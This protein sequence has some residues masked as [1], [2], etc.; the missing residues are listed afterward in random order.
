MY[1]SR[2]DYLCLFDARC[3]DNEMER[4]IFYVV[5]YKAFFIL[6]YDTE[7]VVQG[8]YIVSVAR[9]IYNMMVTT[10]NGYTISLIVNDTIY[11]PK[12]YVCD[13]VSYHSITNCLLIISLEVW[14]VS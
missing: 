8:Y 4:I 13:Q 14:S 2:Y 9:L 1:I 10:A 11:G 3:R 7:S 6:F 5:L 12:V